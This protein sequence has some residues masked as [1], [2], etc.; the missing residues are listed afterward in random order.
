MPFREQ[1]RQS[2]PFNRKSDPRSLI[3]TN[4]SSVFCQRNGRGKELLFALLIDCLL[5]LLIKQAIIRS[6][7]V[8]WF[9]ISACHADD[10]GS[11][12]RFG[13]SILFFFYC[14]GRSKNPQYTDTS[15]FVDICNQLLI[16]FVNPNLLFQLDG[17]DSSFLP[18]SIDL[19]AEI[20]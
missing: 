13:V 1:D 14:Q 11:I 17:S 9:S 4:L 16:A 5:Q 7:V 8:Q 20:L 3:N 10:R 12:P 19:N 6:E 15:I 18:F 2:T